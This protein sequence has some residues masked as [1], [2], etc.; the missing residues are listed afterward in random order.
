MTDFVIEPMEITIT[1]FLSFKNSHS[2]LLKPKSKNFIVGHGA[3]DNSRSNGAGK[4]S[5]LEAFAYVFDFSQ[6]SAT[7]LVCWDANPEFP[8]EVKL[9]CSIKGQNNWQ[10]LIITRGVGKYKVEIAYDNYGQMVVKD[11]YEGSDARNFLKEMLM[12]PNLAAYVTYRPQGVQGNFLPLTPSEKFDKLFEILGMQ[13]F[14]RFIDRSKEFRQSY[15]DV[16]LG[17]E[18]AFERCEAIL[19]ANNERDREYVYQENILNNQVVEANQE[20]LNEIEPSLSQFESLENQQTISDEIF[21]IKN[22]QLKVEDFAEPAKVQALNTKKSI[23]LAKSITKPNEISQEK[24]TLEQEVHL[25]KGEVENIQKYLE[26][27]ENRI[28]KLIKSRDDNQIKAEER[29]VFF[30]DLDIRSAILEANAKSI[31]MERSRMSDFQRM[32]AICKTEF[33]SEPH[34]KKIAALEAELI[35]VEN[36]TNE[37]IKQKQY[38]EDDQHIA[39]LTV[40]LNKRIKE[41]KEKE[42]LLLVKKQQI[43]DKENEILFFDQKKQAQYEQAVLK[44]E[45]EIKSIE[46]DIEAL[47]EKQVI[48]YEAQINAD[49]QRVETLERDLANLKVTT[50]LNYQ[51]AKETH[52]KRKESIQSRLNGLKDQQTTLNTK[53]LELQVDKGQLEQEKI[54]TLEKINQAKHKVNLYDEVTSALGKDNFSRFIVEDTLNLI[55]DRAND[56]IKDLPNCNKYSLFFETEQETKKGSIK[57][58]ILFKVFENGVER[59]FKRLSGG[60]KC[61]INLAVDA[62]ISNILIERTGVNLNWFIADEM[63]YGLDADTKVQAYEVLQKIYAD[64]ILLMVEHSSEIEAMVPKEDIIRIVK[65][66]E[67]SSIA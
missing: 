53:M 36:S 51:K 64:R 22:R 12:S 67:G 34:L 1:N 35:E 4:T 30:K 20:F 17:L 49:K 6:S 58:S 57:K 62:A 42:A 38:L 63:F 66:P 54:A 45:A 50:T 37:V 23:A 26:L 65:G 8:M 28:E 19:A 59:S 24:Q 16:R 47:A 31:L 44:Q 29:K 43:K 2:F 25:L 9:K 7:E 60:E 41:S 40:N 52:L 32:C 27:D 56:I 11:T 10:F 48:R 33:D 18:G 13:H 21:S 5:L 55:A 61:S 3:F 46:K 14:Q 39:L 15:D